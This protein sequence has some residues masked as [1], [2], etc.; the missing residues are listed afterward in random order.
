MPMNRMF[1]FCGLFGII[2]FSYFES[3]PGQC[4]FP[5]QF[6]N[7]VWLD[8]D[9]GELQFTANTMAGW[10]LRTKLNALD[11]IVEPNWECFHTE[12][13]TDST[14]ILLKTPAAIRLFDVEYDTYL[15][16]QM[17]KISTF[18]YYYYLLWAQQDIAN[19]ERIT[20]KQP[21]TSINDPKAELCLATSQTQVYPS[22]NEYHILLKQGNEADAIQDCPTTFYGQYNYSVTDTSGP[23]TCDSGTGDWDVCTDYQRMTFNYTSCN[24]K[25]ASSA[26][27]SVACV[28]SMTSGSNTLVTVYNEDAS[29][30]AGYERFTCFI[31][32]ISSDGSL[33]LS[34]SPG[35]CP[36]DQIPTSVPSLA[37][38]TGVGLQMS[39][40][41]KD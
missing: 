5:S 11:S 3:V 13:D 37:N 24:T 40:T 34:Q 25:I 31:S 6:Q 32:S 23:V 8:S 10:E 17:K 29:V 16:M 20:I 15:C 4:E 19:Q 9:K 30:V 14:Y 2:F 36:K 35:S 38:G 7:S 22:E 12:S 41:P 27:G 1:K 28:F 21:G 39:L 26:N 33:E 18:S